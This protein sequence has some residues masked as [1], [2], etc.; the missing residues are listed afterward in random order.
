[1]S[2]IANISARQILDSRREPTIETEITTQAG[3]KGV[4]SV[5]SGESKG[6]YEAA[7]VP[8]AKAVQYVNGWLRQ[9]VT[10]M[11]VT[12][13][14]QID[15]AMIE[16]DGTD[17]KARFGAN[18]ILSISLAAS[19]A[20][21]Q[22]E[23]IALYQYLG[24]LIGL[25]SQYKI[26]SPMFNLINGGQHAKNNLKIQEFM[27]VPT[28]FPT[29]AEK[30]EAGLKI[31]D[32]IG[33]LLQQKNIPTQFGDEGGY[34]PNLANEQAAIEILLKA[35]QMSGYE[36][37][38]HVWIA[39]DVAASS[40]PP[41]FR[42]DAQFFMDLINRYPIIAIEDPFAQD[43]WHEWSQ[44]RI[45]LEKAGREILL[46]GDDVFTTNLSRLQR[47][48]ASYVG[49]SILIKLNQIGTL[50]ETLDVIDMAKRQQYT[51]I[52]SH[53]SGETNDDY[54]ADLAVA[55]GAS[56]LKAGASNP[57]KRERMIKYERIVQIEKELSA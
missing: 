31:F 50:S 6:I 43:E 17:N 3:S 53:R 1:M 2:K 5:P 42:Y 49:N 57:Q 34:A 46:V 30:L 33:K 7:T 47:G 15:R 4:A 51:H 18:A 9:K 37:K 52:I 36:T 22:E 26:P 41:G 28:G 8:I 55:T 23:Q 20:A 29:F 56:Y 19:R 16:F 44:L 24:L 45:E 54:I 32:A 48:V 25:R 21:A 11:E 12:S 35:I 38:K 27:V 10:G 14:R 40:F 13:Q 39:L